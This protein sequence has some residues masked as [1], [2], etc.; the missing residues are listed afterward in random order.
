[1]WGSQF[2]ADLITFDNTDEVKYIMGDIGDPSI[3]GVFILYGNRTKRDR[4]IGI[5]KRALQ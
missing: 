4:S 2:F 3:I 1:M 5:L